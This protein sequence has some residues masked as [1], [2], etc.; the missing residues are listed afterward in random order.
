[1][2]RKIRA[3]GMTQTTIEEPTGLS[4][5]NRSTAGD[6]VKMAVASVGW[7]RRRTFVPLR[8]SSSTFVTSFP[9]KLNKGVAQ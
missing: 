7:L 6:L 9:A 3:L 1:M 8:R 5:H 4:P 2:R